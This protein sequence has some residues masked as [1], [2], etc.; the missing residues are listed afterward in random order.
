MYAAYNA[1]DA[2][3]LLAL[4]TDDVDW[5]D[6]PLRMHGKDALRDYWTRQWQR[7]HTHDEP[8]APVAL[9][10]GR[11]AVHINRPSAPR[12]GHRCRPAG[13]ATC[14]S[15]ATD[16]PPGSTSRPVRARA[17]G[18]ERGGT[19]R[20]PHR[21]SDA[22]RGRHR[23]LQPCCPATTDAA[24]Q[25]G[26]RVRIRSDG[27]SAT[28]TTVNGRWGFSICHWKLTTSMSPPSKAPVD[29]MS[30]PRPL[31]LRTTVARE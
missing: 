29:G 22:P 15:S 20:R 25:Q 31:I 12:T 26:L 27:Y 4:V 16:W 19:S 1:R 24:R 11:Y 9:G 5:P 7:V 13:S 23:R 10:G 17:A 8:G 28:R 3:G 2:D 18:G 21:Y 6:G 30:M 14:Y